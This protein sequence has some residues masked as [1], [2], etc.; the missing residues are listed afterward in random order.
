[1]PMLYFRPQAL[2][3]LML[4][5]T[6]KGQWWSEHQGEIVTGDNKEDK[7]N[8]F[9]ADMFPNPL[10]PGSSCTLPVHRG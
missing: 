4:F 8:K 3:I 10:K 6:K 1:M 2:A 9:N 5:Q 7:I